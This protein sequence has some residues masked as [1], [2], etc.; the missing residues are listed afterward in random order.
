MSAYKTLQ[1]NI[2]DLNCLIEALK[3][4]G[5][6]AEI[7]DNPQYLYGYQ[8]DKRDEK[9][10]IIVDRKQLNKL[11]GAS[12]DIGFKWNYETQKY[13][14]IISE[15]DTKFKMDLRIIQAY[16]KVVIE[17]ALEENGYKIKVNINDDQFT[18]RNIEDL[19]IIARKMI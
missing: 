19:N 17:K 14:L 6:T 2:V 15:Y 16:T 13:D 3:L 9:A 5:L 4:L 18:K 8:N 1:C 12:N 11:T 7:Y 10:N